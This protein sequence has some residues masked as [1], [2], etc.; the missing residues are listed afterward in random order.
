MNLTVKPFQDNKAELCFVVPVKSPSCAKQRLS[1]VLDHPQR[2]ALARQLYQHTLHYLRQHFPKYDVLV[3]SESQDVLTTSETLGCKTLLQSDDAGLNS[4]MELAA[5]EITRQGYKG[6]VMLPADLA[7]LS[8][9]ELSRLLQYHKQYDL[10]LAEANDGGTNA[11]LVQPANAIRFRFGL[12]SAQAHQREATKANLKVCV[13]KLPLMAVDI[14]KA[15]DLAIAQ[16]ANSNALAGFGK[17]PLFPS[18]KSI[19][20]AKAMPSATEVSQRSGGPCHA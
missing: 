1:D 4:A 13:L 14:D 9:D 16:Q 17:V 8:H 12:N 6:M 15:T 20:T 3:V 19:P 18:A 7:F 10:I 5:S 2:T 11:L